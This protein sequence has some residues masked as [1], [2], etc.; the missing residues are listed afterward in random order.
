MSDC[1]CQEAPPAEEFW[2]HLRIW[3]QSQ[4]IESSTAD[5]TFYGTPMDVADWG[6]VDVEVLIRDSNAASGDFTWNLETCIDHEVWPLWEPML[7]MDVPLPVAGEG[8]LIHAGDAFI[9]QIPL[10]AWLRWRIKRVAAGARKIVVS[11]KAAYKERVDAPMDWERWRLVREFGRGMEFLFFHHSTS[12]RSPWGPDCCTPADF[13]KAEVLDKL[14]QD[15]EAAL[16]PFIKR[17][18]VPSVIVNGP[19]KLTLR[20][21]RGLALP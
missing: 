21:I 5:E 16:S 19:K 18:L 7:A 20:V 2:P 10:R 3:V 1:R 11:V 17:K 6:L 13:S 12:E 4:V 14:K 8:S 9:S 15:M